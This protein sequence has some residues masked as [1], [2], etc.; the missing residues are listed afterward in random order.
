MGLF[1]MSEKELLRI[2][3]IE[4]IQKQRISVVQAAKF[5]GISRRQMTRLVADFR[6]NGALGLISKKRGKPSNRTYSVGF[7]DYVVELVRQN[8]HDFGPTLA[9]E[10][11]NELHDVS[12]SKETLRK[13]MIQAG[14]WMS[15]KDQRK[16][17]IH[18]PRN[19]RECFGELIQID[20]S[21]HWW[22]EE[23]GP[24]CALLV[25]IDDA[26]SKILHLRFCKT[27]NAFDYFH[28]AKECLSQ[29]GK[30][31]AFYSDKHAVFRTI[32]PSVKDATSGMTQFGRALHEL[33]IDIICANSPQ[34]KGRVERA[35]KT[36]QDR[37][38]K[39]LRLR[40][41]S[42]IEDANAFVPA[43]TADFNQ[44]FGKVP[45][46]PKDVHRPLSEHDSLDGAMCN[47]VERTLSNTLTLRY[48][49][50]LFILDKTDVALG[51]TRKKVTICDYPDGRVEIQYDGVCLPYRTFDKLRSV[52]RA[53]IV[54]NKRLDAVL[55]FVATEQAKREL[56]R[57]GNAPRRT[58]QGPSMFDI[59]KSDISG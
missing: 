40:D 51:L 31:L 34:A 50:V 49:K 27:E 13:W 41:I 18:Q 56:K 12:V 54:E 28:A 23:R 58:G 30:P 48:D 38:V 24:R 19:R 36:L 47:K 39:E 17:H 44:R 7:R 35:N 45:R 2:K 1:V 16:Q 52:N 3:I 21:H 37:L 59:P 10:K 9:L 11:L 33:N 4:D 53:E 32:H 55:E 57:S 22:F 29:Y 15:R 26:T 46:N 8:Y 14:I 25:F 43:F 20:G 42:T 5:V 6:R